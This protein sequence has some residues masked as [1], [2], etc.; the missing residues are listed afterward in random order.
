MALWGKTRKLSGLLNV[1]A[2][3][4]VGTLKA[5]WKQPQSQLTLVRYAERIPRVF[6]RV[7]TGWLQQEARVSKSSLSLRPWRVRL[8]VCSLGL[9]SVPQPHTT[10]LLMLGTSL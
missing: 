3:S 4:R 6:Y 7:I 9:L 2:D 8:S 5:P 10:L 1:K